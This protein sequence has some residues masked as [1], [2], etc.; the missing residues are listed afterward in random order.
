[1]VTESGEAPD[2]FREQ[3]SAEL[4][5]M[6]ED[7]L[8]TEKAHFATATTYAR[9]H[10]WL[11]V[12]ATIAAAVAAASIVAKALPVISGSA[13]VIAAITSGIVA[14]LKPQDTEQKHLAAGRRLGALRVKVRQSLNLDL[15]PSRPVDPDA[16]RA[17]AKTFA[18]EKAKIDT[19]APG[20]SNRAF[21]AARRKI[22]AGHF[23]HGETGTL[24]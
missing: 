19:D 5:A 17:S 4:R 8:W 18:E 3:V 24:R 15:H 22:E 21:Q 2:S 12:V 23:R 10:L 11:G 9:M 13:A 6:E 20:T 7:L 1:M 14:F 16:W